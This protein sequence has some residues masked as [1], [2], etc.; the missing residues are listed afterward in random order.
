[1]QVAQA[2]KTRKSARKQAADVQPPVVLHD[3]HVAAYDVLS[4][5]S[6][7]QAALSA[8][9]QHALDLERM[10]G[11]AGP[12]PTPVVTPS[13]ADTAKFASAKDAIRF[14]L[15]HNARLSLADL[16]RMSGKSEVNVRTM[17]SDLRTAKYCGKQG[18]F[19]TRAIREGGKVFYE[20]VL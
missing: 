11:E 20:R 12:A 8:A 9:Q 14:L 4:R 3:A 17:L 6:A 10:E 2:T 19:N 1:M 13:A 7:I 16:V 18:V 5:E 15:T